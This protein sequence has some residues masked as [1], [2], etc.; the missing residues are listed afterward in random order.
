MIKVHPVLLLAW[1]SAVF[2]ANALLAPVYLRALGVLGGLVFVIGDAI[3]F[4]A[5]LFI[6]G[7]TVLRANE[8]R[9]PFMYVVV[10]AVVPIL[11]MG[12]A[13]LFLTQPLVEWSYVSMYGPRALPR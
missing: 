6:A 2:V 13:A 12:F 7:N 1:W 8:S 3:L 4:V 5:G 9:H 10:F 11:G